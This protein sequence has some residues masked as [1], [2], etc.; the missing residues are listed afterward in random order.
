MLVFLLDNNNNIQRSAKR[1]VRGCEMFFPAL[2]YLFCLPL[3]GSC[4]AIFAYLLAD[5]CTHDT[6][7]PTLLC[8]LKSSP[9]LPHLRR[10]Q[11]LFVGKWI[12]ERKR[13][14][15]NY[16]AWWEKKFGS[17]SEL[18]LGTY[19]FIWIGLLHIEEY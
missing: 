6:P 17:R 7:F 10:K 2:A 1:I 5:L 11:S 18:L 3:P 8:H 4:L 15:S 19:N 12:R 13:G 9:G 16:I 14:L